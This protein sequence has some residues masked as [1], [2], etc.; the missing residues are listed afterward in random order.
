ML[1][2]ADIGKSSLSWSAPDECSRPRRTRG[3]R[4]QD[5]DITRNL[6]RSIA[7]RSGFIELHCQAVV[8]QEKVSHIADRLLHVPFLY[9]DL[10][11]DTH[12]TNAAF[13][14][15]FGTGRQIDL[16]DLDRRRKVS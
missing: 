14:G 6:A 7:K 3:L 2:T 1:P 10:L 8:F 15:N 5:H 16:D 12:L 11:M 13:I 9:P 4:R